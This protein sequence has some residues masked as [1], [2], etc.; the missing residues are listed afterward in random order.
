MDKL[1]ALLAFATLAGF[2]GILGWFVPE[3]DLV[4][5]IALTVGLIGYDFFSSAWRGKNG[6]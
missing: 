3:I 2:L 6:D 4:L 5:V 1:M